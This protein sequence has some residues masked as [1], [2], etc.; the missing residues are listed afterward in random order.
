MAVSC[1]GIC[2]GSRVLPSLRA[3]C[4]G[5]VPGRRV[6]GKAHGRR[7]FGDGCGPCRGG[8]GRGCPQQ[9]VTQM[10]EALGFSEVSNSHGSG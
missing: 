3:E 9:F 2:D 8:A 6:A 4:G 1:P 7:S 10:G 5:Q